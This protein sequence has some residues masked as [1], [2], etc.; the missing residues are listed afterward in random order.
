[1]KNVIVDLDKIKNL[2]SPKRTGWEDDEL[3]QVIHIYKIVLSVL[4]TIKAGPIIESYF[5]RELDV[6]MGFARARNWK[7]EDL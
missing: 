4:I 2:C 6:L 3:K 5:R 1:M 7:M